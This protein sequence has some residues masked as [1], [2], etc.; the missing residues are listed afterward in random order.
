MSF[1]SFQYPSQRLLFDKEENL[2]EDEN[3]NIVLLADGS[4]S[5]AGHEFQTVLSFCQ[6]VA[7]LNRKAKLA[8]VQFSSHVTEEISLVNSKEFSSSLESKNIVQEQGL[9][10]LSAG[11]GHARKI[12][13]E[14]PDDASKVVFIITDGKPN[15]G[16]PFSICRTLDLAR[17]TI[18]CVG[19]GDD[20]DLDMCES[21]ASPGFGFHFNDFSMLNKDV[22][23]LFRHAERPYDLEVSLLNRPYSLNDRRWRFM[24]TV[25]GNNDHLLYKGMKIKARSNGFFSASTLTVDPGAAGSSQHTFEVDLRVPAG[26]TFD[27][28]QEE[29]IFDCYTDKGR[30][31][32]IK[33]KLR[34]DD[35]V[36]HFLK[37]RSSIGMTNL[38]LFGVNG[39]G[40]SSLVQAMLTLFME[41]VYS[42]IQIGDGVTHT[43]RDIRF[44][45]FPKLLGYPVA[46][47]LCDTFGLAMDNW[48][49]AL[50][51]KLITGRLPERFSMDDAEDLDESQLEESSPSRSMHAVVMCV[52][53]E[54]LNLEAMAKRIQ[55][56]N[57]LSVQNN[58]KPILVV[59]KIDTAEPEVLNSLANRI[60]EEISLDRC[61]IFFHENYHS[62][63]S[64]DFD[65]D[66]S[67]LK[68]LDEALKRAEQF[69]AMHVSQEDKDRALG[70]RGPVTT[71]C[72]QSSDSSDVFEVELLEKTMD[73][74]YE[75]IEKEMNIKREFIKSVKRKKGDKYLVLNRSKIDKLENDSEIFVTLCK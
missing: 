41:R 26:R 46:F 61:N 16:D 8:L 15:T 14:L 21:I 25:V 55:E 31:I 42:N 48:H 6:S 66:K 57:Q 28:F 5:I 7:G 9:T 49:P 60:E 56:F 43:T 54:S 36:G 44:Y 32:V 20:T 18:I 47:D 38:L 19:I 59:T 37:Y 12:L 11:V 70:P 40:K 62:S 52:S 63:N 75:A 1:N 33:K 4:N 51:E 23:T 73:G 22:R 34:I 10:D 24:I 29:L 69:L 74:L 67:T 35:I 13:S 65:I 45:K 2:L 68:I 50:F 72:A 3:L 71:L 30:P 39:V 64:K 58:I 53:H 17:I 27:D